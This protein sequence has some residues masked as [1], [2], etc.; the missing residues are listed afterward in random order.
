VIPRP[1]SP[2]QQEVGF[3]AT[4]KTSAVPR[5]DRTP[6]PQ[7]DGFFNI[8]EERVFFVSPIH[9]PPP[10]PESHSPLHRLSGTNF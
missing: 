3:R 1:T 2:T 5:V 10:P 9:T 4:V 6:S 7:P 8:F